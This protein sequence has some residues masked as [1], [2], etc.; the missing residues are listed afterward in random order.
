MVGIQPQPI[1]QVEAPT[2]I[3]HEEQAVLRSNLSGAQ[4]FSHQEAPVVETIIEQPIIRDTHRDVIHEHHQNVVEEIH[5]DVIHQH[6]RPV[7]H[8]HI[9]PIIY[10]E[11]IHEKHIPVI[12]EHQKEV[13]HE[14]HEN[15]VE[16]VHQKKFTEEHRGAMYFEE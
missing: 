7:I 11:H 6:H 3:R 2:V 9:Q 5:K 15:I 13:I 12:H 10:Q 14:K 1:V 8:E 16:D 4:V